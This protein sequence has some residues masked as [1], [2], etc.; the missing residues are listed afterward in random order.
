MTNF[1]KRK[2][3]EEECRKTLT[4]LVGKCNDLKIPFFWSCCVKNDETGSDYV[5]DGVMT[6]SNQIEL[7]DDRIKRHLLV[8]IGFDVIPKKKDMEIFL[9]DPDQL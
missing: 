6:G 2:Q 3:F 7:K 9:D 1:D 4:E 8:N 5:S